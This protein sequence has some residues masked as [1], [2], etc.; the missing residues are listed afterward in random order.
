M[1]DLIY[2][3]LEPECRK[4]FLHTDG[5]GFRGQ[6]EDWEVQTFVPNARVSHGYC[7]QECFTKYLRQNFPESDVEKIIKETFGDETT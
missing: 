1:I 3:C 7:G 6:V 5:K 2:Q 4:F